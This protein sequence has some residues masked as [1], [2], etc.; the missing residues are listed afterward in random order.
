[1]AD[2][3]LLNLCPAYTTEW[4]AQQW[5]T[6]Q[7]RCDFCREGLSVKNAPVTSNWNVTLSGAA[8]RMVLSLDPNKSV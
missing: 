6:K 7:C 8:G 4:A 3:P 5:L 2:N 1:M